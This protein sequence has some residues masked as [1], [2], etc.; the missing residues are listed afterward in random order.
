MTQGWT[1]QH[2]GGRTLDFN[3]SN[4][5]IGVSRFGGKNQASRKWVKQRVFFDE[6]KESYDYATNEENQ[7]IQACSLPS[8]KRIR[9]RVEM[10]GCKRGKDLR[11]R[12]GN[13][14]REVGEG[15]G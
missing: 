15:V 3:W 1:P 5:V 13:Q 8:K 7:E 14:W 2:G 6:C 9:L 11:R 12:K 4:Q 10:E